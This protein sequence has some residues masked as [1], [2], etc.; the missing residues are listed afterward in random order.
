MEIVHVVVGAYLSG[1]LEFDP[2]YRLAGLGFG[3][4]YW[5]SR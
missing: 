1:G 5:F 3:V 2:V 4:P